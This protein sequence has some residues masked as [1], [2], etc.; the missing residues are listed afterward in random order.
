[1]SVISALTYLFNY[2]ELLYEF[3]Y[4]RNN[5]TATS[6]LLWLNIFAF[7]SSIMVNQLIVVTK[8]DA[9][10]TVFPKIWP[11]FKIY[12]NILH[13]AS[14]IFLAT[15][16]IATFYSVLLCDL[17]SLR[18]LPFGSDNHQKVHFSE[19]RLTCNNIGC[20][21]QTKNSSRCSS[22]TAYAAA[23]VIIFVILTHSV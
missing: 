1:V 5:S 7:I 15:T 19:T 2:L 9:P 4:Q 14:V 16:T 21:K 18:H 11:H 17:T 23:T 22:I 10:S 6:T 20:L 3:R 8:I 13:N 12:C